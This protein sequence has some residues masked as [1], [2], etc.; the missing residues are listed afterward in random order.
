MLKRLVNEAYFTLTITTVGP[1]LVKSGHAT[2][3]GP[4]MTP[5]LTFRDGDWQVYL[6][7]SSLKP[8]FRTLPNE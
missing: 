1:V 2:L 8:K 5:V 3:Y 6:P 7:G 4:D